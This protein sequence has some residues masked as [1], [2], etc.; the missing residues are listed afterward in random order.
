MGQHQVEQ[1]LDERKVQAFMGAVLDDL[2]ALDYMIDHDCI[3]SG[4][5]RVGAEQEMFLVD[6]NLRPAPLAVEVLEGI[7]EPRLTT[8]IARFNL[9]ANIT[10]QLIT[11]DCFTRVE[12]ELNE[13]LTSTR[14]RAAQFD[15]EILLAGILPTLR[16]SDLTLDNLS[17]NPR[18]QELN[19]A[20]TRLRGGPFSIHIKG[21]DELQIEHDNLM[22][23]SCNTSFQVHF[24]CG[25]REFAA[26]YNI[27]QAITAPVLAAAVNSPILFGQRLWQETRLA[28]FQHSADERSRMQQARSQ[29]TRVGFGERWLKNSVIELLQDQLTR[30][31]PIMIAMPKE[32]SLQMLAR[33]ETPRLAALFM[34]NGTVWPWNRACYGVSNG[35]AQLRIE[36]RALP[37]GPTVADEVAN[38]A[39]FVG[40]MLALPQEYGDISKCMDFDDAKANFFAAARYDLHAQLRW[41][42]KKSSSAASLIRDQLLPLARQGLKNANVDASDIDKYLGIIGERVETRQTGARWILKSLASMEDLEPKDLRYRELAARM[43]QEQKEGL[44]VHRW[45]IMSLADEIDWS[46]SYQTVEQ[47]MSTDLFTVRP[48]DL[49]DLAASVMDWRHVRHVPVEDEEGR[50]VGLITHRA[51]LHL[52]SHG[53]PSSGEKPLTVREIMKTDPLTVSSSTPTLEAMEMMQNNKIGCLPVVD[54]GRLVGILTSYDFLAGAARIFREYLSKSNRA[55]TQPKANAQHA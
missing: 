44:P 28:L 34:H 41:I 1:E 9:E 4:V 16:L 46:Q 6:R 43:L 14:E 36:N 12:R 18:Y 40:L 8:E 48:D 39:F 31:R 10:P 15:A 26:A 54:D 53:L 23:E 55:N 35:V 19:R 47:F 45:E 13:L 33:G 27:A 7:D 20:V 25:P 52:F 21:L 32:N 30:F 42:D 38:T 22:M 50:L 37:A 11:G 17:P 3:E 5:H 24:Q 51:L 49:V 29:P 2:R